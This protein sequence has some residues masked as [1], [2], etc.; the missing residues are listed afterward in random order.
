VNP[1][2]STNALDLN[3]LFPGEHETRRANPLDG[4]GKHGKYDQLIHEGGHKARVIPTRW[5]AICSLELR[6]HS[7][8]EI[9]EVLGMSLGGVITITA[10]DSYVT[11]RDQMLGELDNEFLAMKPLAFAALKGALQSNNENT[12][13]SAAE[14]FFKTSGFMQH[15]KGATD[16]AG[17]VSAE[18]VA[19]QL[20]IQVNVTVAPDRA[21]SD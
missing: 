18:D 19:R 1:P 10:R 8:T 12:A 2:V 20:L 4:R 13:L 7:K 5:R 3:T 11:M 9:A 15:G 14:T 17:P 6:G 21:P 16:A